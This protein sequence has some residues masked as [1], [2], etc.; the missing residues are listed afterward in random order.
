[1]AWASHRGEQRPP[2]GGAAA[3]GPQRHGRRGPDLSAGAARGRHDVAPRLA[4][5]AAVAAALQLFGQARAVRAGRAGPG[6]ARRA[7]RWTPTGRSSSTC[8]QPSRMPVGRCTESGPTGVARLRSSSACRGWPT[9]S[10]GWSPRT[11]WQRVCRAGLA[12]PALVGGEG[13]VESAL[14]A[15]GVV[16]KTGAEGVYGAGWVQGGTAHGVAL[17]GEDGDVRGRR[18]GAGGVA[19]GPR[20]GAARRLGPATG[21]RGRRPRRERAGEQHDHRL[22]PSARSWRHRAET[23]ARYSEHWTPD[24]SRRSAHSPN[25]AGSDSSDR[26]LHR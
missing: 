5:R 23:G 15:A 10:A 4:G 16:A 18:G 14:L 24:R 7:G 12:H 20:R 19:G 17:K 11:R 2:G 6:T 8:W 21:D 25:A 3:A 26:R 9:A 13:R 22:R 1:M